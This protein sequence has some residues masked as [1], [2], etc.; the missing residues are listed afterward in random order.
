MLYAEAGGGAA[1]NLSS[2]NI[3]DPST[4]A[5]GTVEFADVVE[6]MHSRLPE[7]RSLRERLVRV[8]FDLDHPWWVKDADFDLEYHVRELALPTPG[9]A[10]Q[11]Y[12]QVARIHSRPFDFAKPPW[13]LYFITG[14]D[15]VEGVPAG[16]FCI[17]FRMHHTIVDGTTGMEMISSTH[18]LSPEVRQVE[19]PTEAWV[20]EP[21][22]SPLDLLARAAVGR[23]A[24]PVKLARAVA[25]AVPVLGELV[26]RVRRKEFGIMPEGG[27]T[28]TR[29][30]APITTDHRIFEARSTDFEVWRR[31]KRAV[32]GATINDVGLSIVGGAMRRYLEHH[33][34]LPTGPMHA[35]VPVS[36]RAK[37]STETDGNAVGGMTTPLHVNIDGAMAR[38]T[39]VHASTQQSK[40]R[41]EAMGAGT[42]ADISQQLPGRLI[43]IGLRAIPEIGRL[44]S[45]DLGMPL[46][47]TNVPGA[48]F[49]IY[50]AGA[51]MKRLYGLGPVLHGL[52]LIQIIGTYAGQA[53]FSLTA[54][55]EIVPD[56]SF[57]A[58]CLMESFAEHDVATREP[59]RKS[60]ARESA[61]KTTAKTTAKAAAKTVRKTAGKAAG[62]SKKR[63]A[64]RAPQR[65]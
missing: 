55:R 17:M 48:P 2:V 13:E 57:Y 16:C 46:P 49:P 52:A 11:L 56:L 59:E 36:L 51:E 30:N 23:S 20:G 64:K 10:A 5:G 29:F 31:I 8:P 44:T 62:T 37:G 21:M 18:D 38:L 50:F 43:G 6:L 9:D 7:V 19:E 60:G 22:P 41:R 14:L 32:P 28:K 58:D 3:Y 61:A 1:N 25:R 15:D 26:P 39:A 42:L 65:R 34:E 27:Y 45:L 24:R 4:A 40:L 53:T 12:T 33:G 63:A 54:S 35:A 47:V